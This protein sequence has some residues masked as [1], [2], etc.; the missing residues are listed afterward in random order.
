MKWVVTCKSPDS[1]P[2]TLVCARSISNFFFFFLS[3]LFVFRG[4][5]HPSLVKESTP[6]SAPIFRAW[7]GGSQWPCSAA[8]I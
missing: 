2:S 1:P 5:A 3:A 8:L 7:P 6:Q 4:K